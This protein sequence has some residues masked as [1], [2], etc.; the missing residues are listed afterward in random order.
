MRPLSM[1][2]RERIIRAVDNKEGSRREIAKRFDVD[3]STITR[4]LQLRRKTGS[5]DPR[6]HGGGVEPA[7]GPE[8]HDRLDELGE[9]K[10]HATL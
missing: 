5:I 1:D 3:T 10:P 6:P 8:D 7:R 2:L 4:L 9:E